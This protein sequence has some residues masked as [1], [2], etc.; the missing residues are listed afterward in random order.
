M[1]FFN[2]GAYM[3]IFVLA[4]EMSSA[5]KRALSGAIITVV[6]SS[7]QVLT[8]VVAMHTTD[9]RT[10]LQV[11]SGPVFLA[12]PLIY[13]LVPESLRWL[14]SKGDTKKASKILSKAAKINKASL[15]TQQFSVQQQINHETKSIENG[16]LF[17]TAFKSKLLVIR[18]LKCLFCWFIIKF[19]Y[20]GLTINS[21]ALAGNKY[22]N[23]MLANIVEVPAI[24]S[25]TYLIDKFGRKLPLIMCMIISGVACISS[26]FVAP[27]ADIEKLF[28]FLLGKVCITI[29]FTVLYVFTSELFPTYVRQSFLSACSTIGSFG[30]IIAPQTPLLV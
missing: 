24:I 17:L 29:A 21:I 28:L 12:L 15:N 14:L 7:T 20:Y 5:K 27:T 4:I 26:E 11:L 3:T 1:S 23:Y 13:L 8:G 30:T 16:Q 10:F 22:V 18:L 6:Y 19:I 2:C 25:S 9:F